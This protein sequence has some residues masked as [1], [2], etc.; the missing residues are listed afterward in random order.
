MLK[1]KERACLNALIIGFSKIGGG[2]VKRLVSFE[3]LRAELGGKSDLSEEEL[4]G[5]LKT[6][7]EEDYI[8]VVYTDRHGEPFLY[9]TLKKRGSRYNEEL[10]ENKNKL[11]FKLLLA[12]LSALV[13]FVA[14]RIL[15]AI[16]S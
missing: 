3:K 11:L 12:V 8:E 10:R 15:Y 13:T 9:L 4:R 5:L 14:G 16:F 6:L 2:C 7:E 1:R